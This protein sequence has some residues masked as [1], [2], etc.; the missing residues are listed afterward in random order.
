MKRLLL[1]PRILG[2]LPLLAVLFGAGVLGAIR[3]NRIVTEPVWLHSFQTGL[4]LAQ[5]SHRPVLL[6]F[7]TPGCS[8]CAKMD[9]ET[10]TDPAIVE[11]SR[12]FVCVV[13]D[14]ETE[15]D[16]VKRYDITEFPT[17]V[18][19]DPQGHLLS[20][21]TGYVPASELLPALRKIEQRRF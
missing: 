1:H 19:T 2:W 21:S 18:L 8:W 12:N 16:V 7:H 20:A 17:T 5:Q 13:V 4:K 6:S 11:L 10:F 14:S 3:E 15:I 9:A